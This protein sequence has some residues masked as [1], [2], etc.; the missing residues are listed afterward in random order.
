MYYSSLAQYDQEYDGLDT[1]DFAGLIDKHSSHSSV[2]LI[3]KNMSWGKL[4]DFSVVSVEIF[5]KYIDNLD[6]KKAI[7]H[8][9][10]N[11][12]FLKLC[13][14]HIAKPYCALFNQCVSKS[15]F[16]TDMKLAEIS[17]MFKK[18]DNLDKENYRSVNILTT[19]SKVFE[20]ILSDQMI[21]FFS[22]IWTPL[23]Q[24]TGNVTAASMLY[25]SWPSTGG[26]LWTIMIMSVQWRWIFPK[27]STVCHMGCL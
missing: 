12:K 23:Y 8:D 5:H 27:L 1:T 3:K 15:I 4:F 2:E 25:S 24:P 20:Y 19:M 16:P 18:N 6:A 13:G 26:K 14:F 22:N 17:P 10:L 9:C 21:M 7:G 11:A